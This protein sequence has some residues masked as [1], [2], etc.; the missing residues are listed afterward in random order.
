MAPKKGNESGP[1]TTGVK[2]EGLESTLRAFRDLPK[3]AERELLKAATAASRILVGKVQAAGRAQGAQAALL[4]GTVKPRTG[5]RPGVTVGGSATL[6]R[7]AAPAADLLYG[8]EFGHGG[9]GGRGRRSG[10]FS[11]HGFK[12]RHSPE[13][14]WIYPTLKAVKP[15]TLKTFREAADEIADRFIRDAGDWG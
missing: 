1:I 11:P 2:V 15:D 4:A 13:G 6:G 12:A 8:S 9:Q 7:N 14:L 10:D 3:E 5:A